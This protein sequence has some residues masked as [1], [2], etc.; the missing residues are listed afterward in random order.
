MTWTVRCSWLIMGLLALQAC[1]REQPSDSLVV[2]QLVK[3]KIDAPE[4][5]SAGSVDPKSGL[6][7]AE[8]WE[9]VRAHCGACHSTRLVTQNRGDR[10]SWLAMIRWMQDSQGLWQFDAATESAILDYL[11]SNY[12]AAL[13]AAL[14]PPN[15]YDD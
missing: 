12:A 13:D 9:L 5:S 7:I 10:E 11:A 2:D 8:Q 14:L 15:P 4:T 3:A 1:S 6:V